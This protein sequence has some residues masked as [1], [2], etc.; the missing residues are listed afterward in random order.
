MMRFDNGGI[1]KIWYHSN[2]GLIDFY[3]QF[4]CQ[5]NPNKTKNIEKDPK[6]KGI[7]LDSRITEQNRQL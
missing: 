7:V 1:G 5:I 6:Q 3:Q 4:P 2:L